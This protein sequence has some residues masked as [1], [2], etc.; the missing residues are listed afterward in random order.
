MMKRLFFLLVA[1]FLV[2]SL[3]LVTPSHAGTVL[4]TTDASIVAPAGTGSDEVQITYTSGPTL[5]ITVLATSTVSVTSSSVSGDT[6]SIFYTPI[7][8]NQELDFT[9]VGTPP[10]SIS[11]V[12][13]LGV[14]NLPPGAQAG[15]LASISISAVPEPASIALLG[16][17]M[18]GFL[19][20]RRLFK[21]TSVA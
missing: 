12:H 20:F 19:A 17:G 2:A 6:L 9:F 10:I 16:I 1:A 4:V 7:T 8:G 11:E 13:L 14:T 18:T 15:V 5:P 21:R 3:G